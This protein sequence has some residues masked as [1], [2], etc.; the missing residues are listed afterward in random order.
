MLF[1]YNQTKPTK[2]NQTNQTKPNKMGQTTNMNKQ[3]TKLSKK[4]ERR[5]RIIR[6]KNR[7]NLRAKKA[8]IEMKLKDNLKKQNELMNEQMQKLQDF[9]IQNGL[10][11]PFWSSVEPPLLSESIADLMNAQTAVNVAEFVLND[12]DEEDA[13]DVEEENEDEILNN[14]Y[15]TAVHSAEQVLWSE[16]DNDDDELSLSFYPQYMPIMMPS[17]IVVAQLPPPIYYNPYM[18][19]Y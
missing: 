2:P 15:Q 18:L 10:N 4:D 9:T 19:H 13:V 12:E 8:D 17:F 7:K 1:N 16:D 11:V 6:K 5:M 3:Q 14:A